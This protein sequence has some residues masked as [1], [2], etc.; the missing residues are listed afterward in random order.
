MALHKEVIG[1]A[2]LWLGDCRDVLPTLGKVDAVVT[3]PPYG[4]NLGNHLGAKDDRRDQVLVKGCYESYD[5]TEANLVDIVVP[6]IRAAL[7]I[8]SRGAVFCAGTQ[9]WHFPK[10]DAVGG[11]FMPAAMGRNKWGF[12]SL[13]TLLLYGAA[14]DLHLGA[15][16]TAMESSESADKNGHPCPKPLGWMTWAVN[17]ASRKNEIVLDPFMGSGT[18]GVACAKLGRSFIGIEIEPR[19]F[20]IACRRIESAYRQTDLFREPPAPKPE[21]LVLA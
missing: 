16:A 6:S 15:R 12:S 8:A 4:V 3:D 5:D 2:E 1:D 20:D 9:A 10:A 14:P 21:Q 18:T 13:S 7:A 11:V 17:L 19:Y